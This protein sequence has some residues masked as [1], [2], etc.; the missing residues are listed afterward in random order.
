MRP[1]RW[2]AWRSAR[3]VLDRLEGSS[4]VRL[5]AGEIYGAVTVA[6][7]IFVLMVYRWLTV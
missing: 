6:A 3:A 2:A 5:R 4:L 1:K 7:L